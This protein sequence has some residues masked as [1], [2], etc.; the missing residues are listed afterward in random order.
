MGKNYL[1]VFDNQAT[2]RYSYI[3]LPL[4]L[5]NRIVNRLSQNWFSILS[6]CTSAR[7]TIAVMDMTMTIHE[8]PRIYLI[9][10]SF[11]NGSQNLTN[12]GV[13]LEMT[14]SNKSYIYQE[15]KS[16][17]NSHSLSQQIYPLIYYHGQE[18]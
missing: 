3:I 2:H 5:L 8:Y 9:T 17:L 18:I 10:G 15:L 13:H 14:L 6:S 1:S 16:R 7:K 11:T 4:S 12:D